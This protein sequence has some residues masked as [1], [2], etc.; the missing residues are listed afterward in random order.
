MVGI[1]N[2]LQS[3]RSL[4]NWLKTVDGSG[5]GLDADTVDGAGYEVGTWTPTL[6]SSVGS[7]TAGTCSGVYVKMGRHVDAWANL[8]I[9]NAGTGSGALQSNLPVAP[10]FFTVGFG[11][12]NAVTGTMMQATLNITNVVSILGYN[13]TY[14]GPTGA[15]FIMMYSYRSAS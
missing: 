4:L 5:S 7:I 9:T 6:T 11:R 10:D 8:N 15:T 3:A 14:V 2:R 12:E 13:N 1:I